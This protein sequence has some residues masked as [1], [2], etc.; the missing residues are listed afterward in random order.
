MDEMDRINRM[1]GVDEVDTVD[2]V[3]KV[4]G[5][6]RVD[7]LDGSIS[8]CVR[9]LVPRRRLGRLAENFIVDR[10]SLK[11]AHVFIMTLS[12]NI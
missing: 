6:N 5:L 8:I 1:D 9:S 10:F 12:T 7:G 2:V 3:D 11:F 4:N